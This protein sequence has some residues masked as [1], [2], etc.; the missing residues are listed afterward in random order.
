MNFPGFTNIS[1]ALCAGVYV[2]VKNETV[3]YVGKSK[4]MISRIDAHRKVWA[5]KRRGK[6]SWLVEM[7]NIPGV[8]FD[9]VH[10]RRCRLEDLD[11]VEREMIDIYRPKYNVQLQ[12]QGKIEAPIPLTIRGQTVVIGAKPQVSV[13]RRF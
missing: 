5:D 8:L 12:R 11:R 2:L 9:E 13:G 6:Q 4:K 1:D 7:L 3:I 10:V